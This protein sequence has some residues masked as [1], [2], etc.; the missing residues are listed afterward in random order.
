[1]PKT[2]RRSTRRGR[3]Q[4]TRRGV[5]MMNLVRAA[6]FVGVALLWSATTDGAQC[7]VNMTC[8]PS[9]TPAGSATT[10]GAGPAPA[11]GGPSFGQCGV[12]MTCNPSDTRSAGRPAPDFSAVPGGSGSSGPNF[13]VTPDGGGSALDYFG[14]PAPAAVSAVP[15]FGVCGVNMTCN[16]SNP[17]ES[18]KT[19]P[20]PKLEPK[21]KRSVADAR[22]RE[23]AATSS[24]DPPVFGKTLWGAETLTG[25]LFKEIH[26]YI[27]GA[28][29]RGDPVRG[30]ASGSSSG[31][32]SAHW[33]VSA[34]ARPGS[35][36]DASRGRH[37]PARS[38]ESR[39]GGRSTRQPR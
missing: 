3:D 8:N 37:L 20:E 16:P 32:S 13:F 12:N 33:T 14:I 4:R 39:V 26:D 17:T 15:G 28:V 5:N 21:P 36:V 9:D 34:H 35:T 31:R 22:K 29:Q 24:D 6:G 25:T 2:A 38:V 1:M 11:A 7:G 10:D 19:D 27:V 18:K 30:G 23:A